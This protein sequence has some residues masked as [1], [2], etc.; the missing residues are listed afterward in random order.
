ML[1]STH[2]TIEAVDLHAFMAPDATDDS[3][4]PSGGIIFED[5]E[6]DLVLQ[7]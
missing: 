2:E 7:A 1:L 3:R 5:L 6:R 4:L